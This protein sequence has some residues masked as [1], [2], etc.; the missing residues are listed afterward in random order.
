MKL[1]VLLVCVVSALECS[2]QFNV[3]RDEQDVFNL[4]SG[5]CSE[6]GAKDVSNMLVYEANSNIPTTCECLSHKTTLMSENIGEFSCYPQDFVDNCLVSV[7]SNITQK[8]AYLIEDE[9]IS[10]ITSPPLD[11]Q[12]QNITDVRVW[13]CDQDD[14]FGYLCSW[15]T[16]YHQ[17]SMDIFLHKS[18]ISICGFDIGLWSGQLLQ[19]MFAC[20]QCSIVKVKGMV[21]YPIN[22][23]GHVF[24]GKSNCWRIPTK[25][26]VTTAAKTTITSPTTNTTA[27][28]T[29]EETLTSTASTATATSP[30]TATLASTTSTTASKTTTAMVTKVIRTTTKG[31]SETMTTTKR[32][33]QSS[34]SNIGVILGVVV[35]VVIF[36]GVIGSIML[37][38]YRKRVA[39]T[40][41]LNN[42]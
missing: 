35:G 24:N 11:E 17:T 16:V 28:A 23:T 34:T 9:I 7:T 13:N 6:Y 21:K 3:F 36:A 41:E 12:C 27:S 42:L 20:D 2:T 25:T 32:H 26:P 40:V 29:T 22:D 8:Q 1:F 38:K 10:Q 39:E 37:M 4:T 15:K 31:T 5:K 33:Q 19:I 14:D 18:D 30:I